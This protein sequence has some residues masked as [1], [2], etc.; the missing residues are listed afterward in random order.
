MSLLAMRLFV[1]FKNGVD[2]RNEGTDRRLLASLGSSIAGRLFMGK[3]F[4]NGA[5]VQFKLLGSLPS[6]HP[7]GAARPDGLRSKDAYQ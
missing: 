4:L 6:T 5:K 2:D 7:A 1:R 3:D